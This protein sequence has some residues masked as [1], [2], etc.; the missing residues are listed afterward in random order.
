M[1]LAGRPERE[2]AH[3]SFL[4]WYRRLWRGCKWYTFLTPAPA[5]DGSGTEGRSVGPNCQAQPGIYEFALCHPRFAEKRVKVYVGKTGNMRRRQATHAAGAS[6][7]A[8]LMHFALQQGYTILTRFKY[9]ATILKESQLLCRY[10]YA[11][12]AVQNGPRRTV[13]LHPR[14]SCFCVVNGLSVQS[15]KLERGGGAG[16][17]VAPDGLPA[18]PLAGAAAGV[19]IGPPAPRALKGDSLSS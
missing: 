17:G 12:N 16:Q 10:D 13:M 18:T 5:S 19:L 2:L 6:H 11:W 7:L 4:S 3:T 9:L 14:T 15:Q 8:P 1:A